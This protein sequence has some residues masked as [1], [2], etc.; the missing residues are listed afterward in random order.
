[1]MLVEPGMLTAV[2]AVRT[3]RSP[4][5]TRPEARAAAIALPKRSSTSV[6][7]GISSGV[8][9]HSIAMCCNEMLTCVNARIGRSGRR[10]ATADAVR[11]GARRLGVMNH[12]LE[13]LG[14]GDGGLSAVE[15]A[16]DDPLLYERHLG[17]ADLD[18]QIATGDHDRVGLVEDV[19]E[20][21]DRFLQ[22]DLRD[23]P[24]PR[25]RLLES[26]S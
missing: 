18:P 20:R 14:R 11:L 22:L 1:M 16:E 23:D 2:P 17:H 5:S 19:L 15:R 6:D 21:V 7:S 4:G 10:R 8:T 9:P 13:H 26:C 24:G 12:G 3:M 25:A